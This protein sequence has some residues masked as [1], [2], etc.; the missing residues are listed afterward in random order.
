MRDDKSDEQPI[1]PDIGEIARVYIMD[2][3]T[4]TTREQMTETAAAVAA[5][6]LEGI[7]AWLEPERIRRLRQMTAA[8]RDEVAHWLATLGNVRGG[9]KR[10]AE[11]RRALKARPDDLPDAVQRGDVGA[12]LPKGWQDPKPYICSAAG[13]YRDTEQGAVRITSRPIWIDQYLSEVNGA[14]DALRICWRSFGGGIVRRIVPRAVAASSRELVAELATHGASITSVSA[15]D[16]VRYLDEAT[17]KNETRIPRRDVSSRLGWIYRDGEPRGFLAGREYIGRPDDP[18]V[19]LM[20]DDGVESLAAAYGTAGTWS[21]YLE[22]VVQPAASSEAFWLSTYN[23]IASILVR[24]LDLG[25]PWFIDR[26]GRTSQGKSTIGKAAAAVWQD[27]RAVPSWNTSKAGVEARAA[28]LR[29]LPLMLDD[30]KEARR[31]DD[32]AA[33]VYMHGNGTG[34]IRGKPGSN[35]RAVGLRATEKWSSAGDSSGEQRLTSFTQDAG[36]RA[37][38]LCLIGSPLA[39]G[40]V[41]RRVQLGA[42][43]HHGHLGRRVVR[44]LLAGDW[45]DLKARFTDESKRLTR[46][47]KADGAV[48]ERLGRI[49]AAL[50]VAAYLVHAVG[51]PEPECDVW[52]AA[53]AS[54]RHGSEDADQPLAALRYVMQR[55]AAER[56]RFW[57]TGCEKPAAQ[58]PAE[59]ERL[60]RPVHGGFAGR[61]NHEKSVDILEY[62]VREWL[63]RG[64]F[65]EG[66]IERWHE[67]GYIETTASS[68]GRTVRTRIAGQTASVYRIPMS[69]FERYA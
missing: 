44:H 23:Q 27:P 43:T 1:K 39:S 32:V 49:V 55:C 48:A 11:L 21:G 68:R 47:L 64:G 3:Q 9:S 19:D 52:A 65:D 8:Y 26:S 17:T 28:T 53:L 37:R 62:V 59:D 12:D 18:G 5:G 66:T 35:G 30:S 69:M 4:G 6:D 2:D 31:P 16:V 10:V 24:P 38:V 50:K 29:D 61:W 34:A 45:G 20:S 60:Y 54:C 7:T 14:G 63:R 22:E 46:A 36:A 41:A 15:S 25:T 42:E 13:L 51:V 67:S 58:D 56:A 33:V 40:E 57:H